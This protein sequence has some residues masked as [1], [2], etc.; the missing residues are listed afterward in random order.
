MLLYNKKN[1]RKKNT[2]FC[3]LNNL[4]STLYI[5]ARNYI[6]KLENI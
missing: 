2:I 4:D 1:L 6:L 5:L 3:M